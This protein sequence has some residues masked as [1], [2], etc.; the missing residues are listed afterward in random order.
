M[1][2][3]NTK[4][5]RIA[6]KKSTA[7]DGDAQPT[8]ASRLHELRRAAGLSQVA[9]GTQGFVSTPGWIKVEN[10][11]RSP[12][13]TLLERFC[14]LLVAEKVICPNQKDALHKELCTLKYA[15]HRSLFLRQLAKDQLA[16]LTLVMIQAH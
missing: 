9:V 15:G 16:T 13:E 11:Q 14:G 5:R 3:T 1:A 8:I 4:A 6:K 7:T 10:S 12:S 2:S